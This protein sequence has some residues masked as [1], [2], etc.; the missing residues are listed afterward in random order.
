MKEREERS[1]VVVDIVVDTRNSVNH[2]AS[3]VNVGLY[4]SSGRV[5]V[6]AKEG[7]S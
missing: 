6:Q 2:G 1:G 3:A 4:D 7:K 5:L